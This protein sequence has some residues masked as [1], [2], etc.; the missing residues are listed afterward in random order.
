[1]TDVTLKPTDID[2]LP[3]LR[4]LWNDGRVMKSVG[5]PKGVGE[6]DESIARWYAKQRSLPNFHHF[7]VIDG[8]GNRCG[9]VCFI[10]EQGRSGLDVKLRPESQGKGIA[11]KALA[12]AINKAFHFSSDCEFVW[13]EPSPENTAARRLYT[14]C[15]L[16]EQPRPSEMKGDGKPFWA[17]HR[18]R[19][20]KIIRQ[21]S[22]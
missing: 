9:E 16:S 12:Q 4:D 15:G 2:D 3:F 5:F 7:I 10:L 22:L 6:T 18:N 8:E 21:K 20:E 11:T 13:T 17:L 14:R 19:W 1:M